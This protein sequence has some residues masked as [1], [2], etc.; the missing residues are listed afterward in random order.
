MIVQV[1]SLFI[2]GQLSEDIGLEI[3]A[4]TCIDC[5]SK[6]QFKNY[7]YYFFFA[8]LFGCRKFTPALIT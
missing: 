2:R 8:P 1:K 6:S 3:F 5:S 4:E 7:Y